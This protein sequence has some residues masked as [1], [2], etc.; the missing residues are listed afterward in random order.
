MYYLLMLNTQSS[1]FLKLLC[2]FKPVL[3]DEIATHKLLIMCQ[4]RVKMTKGVQFW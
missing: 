1:H 3:H 2:T 4:G